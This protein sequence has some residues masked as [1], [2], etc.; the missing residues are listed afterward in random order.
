M[1]EV[2]IEQNL[3]CI[4]KGESFY[5]VEALEEAGDITGEKQR[6]LIEVG[7]RDIIF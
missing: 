4:E 2:P 3:L 5:I 1:R 6:S 7:L